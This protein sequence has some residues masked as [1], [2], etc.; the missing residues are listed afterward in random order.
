MII[1][2]VVRPL[3]STVI[4]NVIEEQILERNSLNKINVVKPFYFLFSA[5]AHTGIHT[6]E[7]S[8][9]CNQCG[10]AIAYQCHFQ[11]HKRTHSREKPFD[12]I[13]CVKTFADHSN[14]HRHTKNTCW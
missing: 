10:K 14:I 8:Y 13:Q 1:I 4:F 2:N 9:G 11:R 6:G 12:F 3:H 7:E 5:N